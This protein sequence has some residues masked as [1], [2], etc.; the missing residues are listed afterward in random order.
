MP[1][2]GARDQRS[3]KG[4]RHV[5]GKPH[6]WGAEVADLLHS[7]NVFIVAV[8]VRPMSATAAIVTILEEELKVVDS[9]PMTQ[10]C[11]LLKERTVLLPVKDRM[12]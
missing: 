5:L 1:A 8:G 2:G 4:E 9:V 3:I 7:V 10:C 6:M 12:N 11:L